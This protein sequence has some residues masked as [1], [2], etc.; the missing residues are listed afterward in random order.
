MSEIADVKF[1]WRCDEASGN[2]TDR[3]AGQVLTAYGTPTYHQVGCRSFSDYSIGLNGST[4][5]FSCASVSNLNIG[6][7]DFSVSF[8]F[9]FSVNGVWACVMEKG[10][11]GFPHD[12]GYRIQLYANPPASSQIYFDVAGARCSIASLSYGAGDWCHVVF[13]KNSTHLKIYLNKVCVVTAVHSLGDCSNSDT[14]HFGCGYELVDRM[15]GNLDELIILQREVSEAEI[16]TLY[17]KGLEICLAKITDTTPR[18]G[19]TYSD[20]ESEAQNGYQVQIDRA[21]TFNS[22]NGSPDFD[23]GI[24]SS[25]NVYHDVLPALAVSG[26]LFV[27]V[28]TRDAN[29]VIGECPWSVENYFI[30]YPSENIVGVDKP[31]FYA[32]IPSDPDNNNLHFTIQVDS[33]GDF[34]SSIINKSSSVSQVGWEYWNGSSWVAVPPGGVTSVY[35]GNQVRYRAQDADALSSFGTYAFRIKAVEA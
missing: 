2:L 8:W 6:I 3:Y 25:V 27:R 15:N 13:I 16:T 11:P 18:I 26:K 12:T 19:W 10:F 29:H 24:I 17:T 5:Y 30:L 9:R 22:N 34:A 32:T 28:R 7:G 20:P 23:S 4:D 31:V 1:Y 33:V 14:F 35:Y 21:N